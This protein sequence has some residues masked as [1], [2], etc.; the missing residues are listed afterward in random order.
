MGRYAVLDYSNNTRDNYWATIVDNLD[1][2]CPQEV[3]YEELY[4]FI[5]RTI[6]G[7]STDKIETLTLDVFEYL[8]LHPETECDLEDVLQILTNKLPNTLIKPPCCN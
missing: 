3:N 7:I 8:Y 2:D 1:P 6:P 5:N 4:K